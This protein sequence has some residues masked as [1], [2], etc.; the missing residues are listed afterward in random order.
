MRT[1]SIGGSRSAG[2]SVTTALTLSAVALFSTII[3][4]RAAPF[5]PMPDPFGAHPGFVINLPPAGPGLLPP[6]GA[7]PP[8]VFPDILASPDLGHWELEFNN[9]VPFPV[10][11][12]LTLAFPGGVVLGGLTLLPGGSMYF[13]IGYFDAP[14]EVSPPLWVVTAVAAPGAPIGPG[15]LIDTDAIE[16][17]FPT[18][19]P[20]LAPPVPGGPGGIFGPAVGGPGVTVTLALI[21]EPSSLALVGIGVVGLA[22][23]VWRRRSRNLA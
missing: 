5:F 1:V 13:D 3:T 19:V 17:P 14:P 18:G 9:P 6:G 20:G 7:L 4:S 22:S 15:I 2:R 21:P 11:F 16:S 8:L 23:C 12:D 10:T